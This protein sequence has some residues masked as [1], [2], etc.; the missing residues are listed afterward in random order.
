MTFKDPLQFK[1]FY[2]YKILQAKKVLLLRITIIAVIL[3][4][5]SESPLVYI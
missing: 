3:T 4:W 1:L 2:D 5:L